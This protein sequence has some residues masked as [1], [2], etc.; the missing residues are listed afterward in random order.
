MMTPVARV[1]DK[2]VYDD[3]PEFHGCG[4]D[5]RV[6]EGLGFRFELRGIAT[7][8][9]NDGGTFC[10]SSDGCPIVVDSSLLWQWELLTGLS[11][12]FN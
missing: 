2:P 12:R 10:N 7:F 9:D 1:R 8:V 3:I 6:T 4:V 5:F 11:F